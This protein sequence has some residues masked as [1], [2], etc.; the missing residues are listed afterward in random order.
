MTPRT[1]VDVFRGLEGL[2][3]PDLQLFKKDGKW[4]PVSSDEFVARVRAIASAFP[5]LGVA[6]GDRVAL[7]AENRPE[8][9]QL[10]FACQCYG[11]VLVPVFPTMVA[12]QVEYLLADSGTV[13]AFGSNA[14]QVKKALDARQSCKGLKHV[15]A[16]DDVPFAGVV[17]FDKVLEDGKAAWAA[18]P[19]GFEERASS[20]KPD[21][22]A[23]LIYTSGT[24]GEPKGAMLTQNNFV[25]NVLAG[26]S[27]LPFDSS[28][29]CMSF[30]PLSHVFERLLEYC[31]YYRG[32]TI[33]FAE[34]ID[35]L[36]DN[37]QEVNP[38]IFGAVPRVYEKVYARVQ[39]KFAKESGL[40]RKLIDAALAAGKE[41]L[42]LKSQGKTPGALL[43][44]QL[45][46]FDGLVF[47][48]IRA[49][50]GSRFRFAISGGAPLG[51]ELAEFFWSVGVEVYEGYGLTETSPV[52]AVNTPAAWRL[53]SVGRI[54]PGVECRI[55]EDGEILARGPNIMKGYWRKEEATKEAI[56]ADGWFHTGD[57][58]V[59]DEDGF[60]K[61]TD[62]KKE[63]LVNANGK[64]IA[65]APIE[66]ALKADP[67]VAQAVCIGD[68]RKFLSCLI[69]PNVEKLVDWA[70]A[71][72]AE[73]KS[74]EELVGDSRVFAL[75]QGIVDR[76]NKDKS[77]EQQIRKF[78]LLPQ[79]LTIEGGE[80]TPTLKVKRR[81]VDKKFKDAIDRMYEGGKD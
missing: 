18:D 77:P 25:S 63:I 23:T 44:L 69:V 38:T 45:L 61:I 68:R 53:G 10:D 17:K 70:K 67:W 57:I 27:V 5:G 51:K 42:D 75:F 34:S 48:K 9:S 31:Y 37:L 46:V 39:D 58:G 24:T 33:A 28:N 56:D 52:I 13:V 80:L 11:A 20:R 49:A 7:L 30:L 73:G 2:K 74:A 62:R 15:V 3:K 76:W 36:R 54:L 79:E 19:N 41:A 43:S 50:L 66:N 65:P 14:D 21:D 26:C 1:L 32:A 64:N 72:G 4:Q 29:V 35:A 12:A 81:I 55:A 6:P 22:L 78:A 59:I 8:W 47:A 71:N 60:L 40:K 16:F